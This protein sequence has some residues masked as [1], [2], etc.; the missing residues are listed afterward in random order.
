[1]E[2]A[3]KK[4][5]I[6]TLS[7]K[8]VKD[9]YGLCAK[10]PACEEYNL[11]SQLRRSVVSIALNIAE[12][13]SRRTAKDFANFLNVS[14]GSVAE[15]GAILSLCEELNYLDNFKKVYS[16]IEILG[17]KINALRRSLNNK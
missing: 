3:Y 10:L 1:M 13:K 5:E 6:W 2:A 12:G 11:K 14:A 8:L 4:L 17:M 7:V 15:V 16:D 9:V